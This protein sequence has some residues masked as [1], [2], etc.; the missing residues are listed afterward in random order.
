[1]YQPSSIGDDDDDD[2]HVLNG[3]R[4]SIIFEPEKGNAKK[5]TNSSILNSSK[6]KKYYEQHLRQ[7]KNQ[8]LNSMSKLPLKKIDKPEDVLPKNEKALHKLP[9]RPP[10]INVQRFSSRN[11]YSGRLSNISDINQQ[12]QRNLDVMLRDHLISN[13]NEN[14]V[15]NPNINNWWRV[16][17]NQ[18]S[19]K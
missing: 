16:Y 17:L 12:K 13:K 19:L 5:T 9:C 2:D 3:G 10:S 6:H 4:S 15:D 8:F 11:T 1:M 18:Q 7:D 14:N